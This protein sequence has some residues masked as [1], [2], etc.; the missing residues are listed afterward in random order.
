[1]T[2]TLPAL[3]GIV[4]VYLLVFCRLG[5]MIML[6]PAIG[7]RTVPARVRLALA[8]AV[9]M[10]FAPAV[11]GSY[12]RLAPQSVPA[13]AVLV[14]WEITIGLL[15]GAMARIVTSSLSV[16]GIFIATQTG[17]A[18]AQTFDPTST[19]DQGAILGN[20][21]AL[22]G[23][24]VVFAANLHYLAIGA[25]FGSYHLIPPGTPLPTSDMAELTIRFVSEAFLL[26][27][28]LAAPF[29]VFTFVV[30]AA[31]GVLSRLMPQLQIFF[32]VMPINVLF[33][34][35]LLALFLGTMMT[36]YLDFFSGHLGMLQ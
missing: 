19:A 3:N 28:Q 32:V 23:T 16:A 2:I 15:I 26:G 14:I 27:F 35:M 10:V 30:N 13:L 8:L 11:E 24:V 31:F 25:V 12:T 22:L 33:G 1:M 5:A 9:T 20:F 4:L 17:L 18:L 6:M 29:I 36:L 7:D 21:L 34:F